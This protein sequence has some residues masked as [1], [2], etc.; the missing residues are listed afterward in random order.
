MADRSS[1]HQRAL[2]IPANTGNV[3][4]NILSLQEYAYV[5]CT[6]LSVSSFRVN[7]G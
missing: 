7:G 1:S 3:K 6:V 2:S 5:I 4:Q